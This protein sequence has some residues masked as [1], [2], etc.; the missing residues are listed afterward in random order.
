M[1]TVQCLKILDGIIALVRDI[2]NSQ[3][4]LKDNNIYYELQDYGIMIK[5]EYIEIPLP[6]TLLDYLTEIK[7]PIITLYELKDNSYISEVILSI[8]LS[9]KSLIEA[10]GAYNFWKSQIIEG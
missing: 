5:G 9:Q 1:Q 4:S 3:I 8:Q 6:C 10:Q 2:D 7:E